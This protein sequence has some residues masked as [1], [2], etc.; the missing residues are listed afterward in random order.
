MENQVRTSKLLLEVSEAVTSICST[1]DLEGV[2]DL[3]LDKAISLVKADDGRI[4]FI[5]EKRE[6]LIHKVSKGVPNGYKEIERKIG[7]GIADSN[8]RC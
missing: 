1:R 7:E 2:L 6:Y 3:I 5:D 8:R 4:R